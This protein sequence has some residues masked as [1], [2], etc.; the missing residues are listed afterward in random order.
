M[1]QFA[2]LMI[3]LLCFVNSSWAFE[4]GT[5]FQK[6]C[7]SCHTVGQGDDVGPDLKDVTKRRDKKWLIRF[8][9][10]SQTMIEEGDP[11]A[12]QIFA[13]YKR[14]KMPDQEIDNS[15]VTES[16]IKQIVS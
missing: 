15:E 9:Q 10:E 16:L 1:K 13:K 6:K 8:I 5:Y 4:P 14:K 11:I 7:M 12:N 3:L 2:L